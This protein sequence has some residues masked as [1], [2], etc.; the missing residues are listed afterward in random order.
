MVL[1]AGNSKSMA[2]T[3]GEGFIAVSYMVRGHRIV[4][5]Q[6]HASQLTSLFFSSKATSLN[7]G[8]QL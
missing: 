8:D 1:E 4:R 5:R 2:L 3:S 7:M 6:E